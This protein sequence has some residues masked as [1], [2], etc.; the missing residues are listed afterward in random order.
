MNPRSSL[1]AARARRVGALLV[2][3]T[4]LSG[5]TS[6]PEPESTAAPAQHVPPSYASAPSESQIIAERLAECMTDQGW[7]VV[8]GSTSY[9]YVGPS[10]QTDAF[11]AAADECHRS[12][13]YADMAA[14]PLTDAVVARA[15]EREKESH[16]CLAAAGYDVDEVPSLAEYSDRLY[17]DRQYSTWALLPPMSEGELRALETRCPDPMGYFWQ[18]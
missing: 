16:A 7:E 6:A 1:T 8:V 18:E 4:L 10:E 15:H 2:L 11:I 5:C 3:A 12:L 9:S 17:N 13:G 14:P